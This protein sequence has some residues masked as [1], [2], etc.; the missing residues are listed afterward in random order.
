MK[1]SNS[2]SK[3]SHKDSK[4]DF[5]E[6][7]YE[8]YIKPKAEG[9]AKNESRLIKKTISNENQFSSVCKNKSMNEYKSQGLFVHSLS[10]N[11]STFEAMHLP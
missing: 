6:K 3:V 8:Q 9:R 1:T 2:F 4:Y 7:K 10:R 5:I 11:Y